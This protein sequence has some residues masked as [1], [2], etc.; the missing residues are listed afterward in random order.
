[1]HDDTGVWDQIK[2]NW[3][4][5]KGKVREKWGLLTDDDLEHIAG[6]KDRLVGKIQERYGEAKWEAS[7]IENE[8]RGLSRS[9]ANRPVDRPEDRR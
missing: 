1:M 4:Q 6:H 7:Q 8:L 3:K 2:G 9:D 5:L